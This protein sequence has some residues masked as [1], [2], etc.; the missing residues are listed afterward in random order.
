M[1]TSQFLLEK[2]S[3]SSNS[4]NNSVKLKLRIRLPLP[5][6]GTK[7]TNLA[8]TKYDLKFTYQFFA[9][10]ASSRIPKI[11][12][13]VYALG[14]PLYLKSMGG[15]KVNANLSISLN[16][17]TTN[18]LFVGLGKNGIFHI[19]SL[20]NMHASAV[21]YSL[22]KFPYRAMCISKLDL[23]LKVAIYFIS[24]TAQVRHW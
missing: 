15:R 5:K 18:F 20:G 19:Y 10:D 12:C 9:T 13:T 24:A 16:F 2:A 6:R 11:I 4:D 22:R 1:S 14:I 7:R 23:V 8:W 3:E 17:I 21:L